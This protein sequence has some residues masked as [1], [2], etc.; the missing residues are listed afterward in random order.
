MGQGKNPNYT[1]TFHSIKMTKLFPE[2]GER[3]YS[4]ETKNYFKRGR[5]L[6]TLVPALLCG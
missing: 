4:L 5:L 1:P 3:E 6:W 2:K